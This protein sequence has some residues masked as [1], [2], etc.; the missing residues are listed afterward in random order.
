MEQSIF[1]ALI[2]QYQTPHPLLGVDAQEFPMVPY[3]MKLELIQNAEDFQ[4]LTMDDFINAEVWR[5]KQLLDA[6]YEKGDPQVATRVLDALYPLMVED[7]ESGNQI[8]VQMYSPVVNQMQS[9]IAAT[10]Q[11]QVRSVAQE[12]MDDPEPVA[13]E[14]EVSVEA[15]L[16]APIAQE[17][18][19]VDTEPV[20]AAPVEDV[21]V[22]AAPVGAEPEAPVTEEAEPEAPIDK[23]AA[24]VDADATSA[25][26]EA[27]RKKRTPASA[28]VLFILGAAFLLA[29][30]LINAL[31][32]IGV[33]TYE[34]L[35]LTGIFDIAIVCV[36]LAVLCCVIAGIILWRSKA[37]R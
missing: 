7:I 36:A 17:E 33:G 13:A 21:P 3:S 18:E 6:A 10:Q 24:P 37:K 4:G 31:P 14:G 15:G 32:F 8:A 9:I 35:A 34:E 22:V 5:V 23:D 19:P 11:P 28:I 26:V 2:D 20:E 30:L 25:P 29:F 1:K 27:R 16:E 12:E